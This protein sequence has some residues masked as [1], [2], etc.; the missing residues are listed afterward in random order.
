MFTCTRGGRGFRPHSSTNLG[1]AGGSCV[2]GEWR[3]TVLVWTIPIPS[4]ADGSFD[5]I[6]VRVDNNQ[7]GAVVF[8]DGFELRLTNA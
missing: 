2:D 5:G 7:P 6:Q 3:Q 1:H 4:D 8:W